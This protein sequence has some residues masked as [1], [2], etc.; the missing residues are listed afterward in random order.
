MSILAEILTKQDIIV[1]DSAMGTEL[2]DRKADISM[3][4]WSA[5]PLIDNP[6][7]I[8]QIHI[9]N[10]DA[11]ADI[12]TTNT[13]RTQK[14]T[15]E[16]AC[17]TVE[18][19]SYEDTARD[20]TYMAVELAKDAVLIAVEEGED[21]VIVAGCISPL[22]DCYKPEL[23]PETDVLCTEHYEHIN[24]LVEGG[25]DILLAETMISIKEISAVLNQLHKAGKEYM[26]SLLCKNGDELFSGEPLKD[27]M[28]IIEKFNPFAVLTNCI[29][30]S[31][32]EQILGSLKKLT[33]KPFG[34]YANIGNP[35]K[36]KSG[37]LEK[38]VSPD[39]YLKYAKK[40]KQM[41]AKIIGGCCGT[42][43]LYIV[44]LSTLK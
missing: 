35:S 34:V 23:V 16:K 40:W 43:P 29:H 12:I 10:I 39:E 8:R 30:P 1:L 21:D 44:K 9:D 41:G 15:F 6:D 31:Q 24:N 20:M 42:N 11:G 32:A 27:A 13:F 28:K 14:R 7:L 36:L 33:D 25:A 26:I 22:E 5:R 3:P 4:L 38:V 2:K 18:G 19:S 17:Y 37:E